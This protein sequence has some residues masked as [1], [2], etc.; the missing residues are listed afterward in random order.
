M[1]EINFNHNISHPNL[2]HE[3]LGSDHQHLLN[4]EKW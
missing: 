2:E 3:K 4:I 1:N